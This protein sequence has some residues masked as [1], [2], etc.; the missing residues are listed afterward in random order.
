M[1]GHLPG[2]LPS[3]AE[4]RAMGHELRRAVPRSAH[5]AWAP[6]AERPDAVATILQAEAGRLA[7]LLPLRHRRMAADAFAF[8]RGAATLMAR[9]LGPLPRSGLRVVACGDAHLGNFGAVAAPEGHAVF[10]LTDFDE[11]ASAPFE[12]DLKR[13]AT[14]LVVSGRVKGL[15]P[16]A[17]RALARRAAHA[18]RRQIDALA[19]LPPLDAWRTRLDLERLVEDI[20]DRDVRRRERQRLAE[21]VQESRNTYAGLVSKSGTLHLPERPPAVFRLGAEETTA[22]AAFTAYLDGVRPDQLA[23]LDRYRLRDVAFKAAGIGSVGLFCALGLFASGDGDVLLLQ[24]KEARASVLEEVAGPS[25]YTAHGERVV[26]AQRTMQA[27]PDPL[28]GWTRTPVDGRSFYVRTLAD[29]RLAS[30]AGPIEA[31]SLRFYALLCARTLARAHCRSGDAA[32]IAGYL[33]E[34]EA[35]DIAICDFAMAY[36]DQTEQDHA[37]WLAA[38][39]RGEIEVAK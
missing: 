3:V 18:Y 4:R 34:G 35:F 8:L 15:P 11:A 1:T 9:D 22:H 28:L 36:A 27:A 38:I 7:A 17:S 10:D 16:R 26:A 19:E 31:D 29:P 25:P 30:A 23:L 32:M 12:W 6:S 5:A 39:R 21:M 20:A 13:L 37:A 2:P 33:G 24:L 14:A